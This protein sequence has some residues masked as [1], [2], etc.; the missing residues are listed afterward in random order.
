[1][2]S[3]VRACRMESDEIGPAPGGLVE[4]DLEHRLRLEKRL[5]LLK[6]SGALRLHG[7]T[8]SRRISCISGI[9]RSFVGIRAIRQ[10]VHNLARVVKNRRAGIGK[11]IQFR[12]A[13]GHLAQENG[14]AVIG[15]RSRVAARA[16]SS[17]TLATRPP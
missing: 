2:S 17:T 9:R 13:V 16:P 14:N 5:R 10:G 12:E 15:I 4:I 6:K 1:M 11:P 7:S 3:K 8:P